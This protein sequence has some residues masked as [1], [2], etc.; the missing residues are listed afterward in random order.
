M[1]SC[2][3]WQCAMTSTLRRRC[4]KEKADRSQGGRRR[5]GEHERWV[6]W[7]EG[8]CAHGRRCAAGARRLGGQGKLV[9][10]GPIGPLAWPPWMRKDN[11]PSSPR[12][13]CNT[14]TPPFTETRSSPGGSSVAD[15]SN[16]GAFRSKPSLPAD[17]SQKFTGKT[18]ERQLDA[19]CTRGPH[20]PNT[21]PAAIVALRD[22]LLPRPGM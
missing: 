13:P 21:K 5:R 1:A 15:N 17:G 16:R 7:L 10:S 14:G 19:R 22:S 3:R 12:T 4:S 8:P 6:A 18:Q 9:C 11:G 2:A 20:S